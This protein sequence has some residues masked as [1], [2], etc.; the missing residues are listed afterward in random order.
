MPLYMAHTCPRAVKMSQSCGLRFAGAAGQQQGTSLLARTPSN[1]TGR[2]QR[3]SVQAGNTSGRLW[4]TPLLWAARTGGAT[5]CCQ[6][7]AE[8]AA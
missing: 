2:A 5:R 8:E 6:M 3:L 1:R 4:A 7:P